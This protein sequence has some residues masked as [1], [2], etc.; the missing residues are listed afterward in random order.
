MAS[1]KSSETSSIVRWDE[2]LAKEAQ[3]AAAMEANTGGGKFLSVKGGVMQWNDS[4][5]PG[6]KMAAIIVDHIF[7]NVMYTEEYDADSP[8]APACFAFGRDEKSMGPHQVVV[9]AGTAQEGPCSS[10]PMNVFGSA[11]KGK[12][13][14]CRNTRRLA[15]IPAGQF[16]PGDKFKLI[17]DPEYYEKSDVAFF[18][19]PVTSVK[20]F[21]A[22]VKQVAAALKRPP[23]GIV[24]RIS[25]QPDPKT[26]FKVVFEA[27]SNVPDKLM[28]VIMKRREEV[29]GTID[30]PYSM[31]SGGDEAPKGK[32]KKAPKKAPKKGRY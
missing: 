2:E 26:Q 6:N 1:K 7:E 3:T 10:C 18:K 24:T 15:L 20:G 5:V 31:G 13:K 12:G 30:F 23:V 9:D 28:S 21:A 16:G 27:M 17:D 8:S 22:Y 19:I 29:K 25:V 32:A 4:P 14:A 11:D